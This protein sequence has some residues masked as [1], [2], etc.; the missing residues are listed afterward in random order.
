MANSKIYIDCSPYDGPQ[1][2]ILQ[3]LKGGLEEIGVALSIV[4]KA[5][6]QRSGQACSVGLQRAEQAPQG[7]VMARL[8]PTP[9]G[10]FAP[11]RAACV[12]RAACVYSE[13]SD[14]E[15]PQLCRPMGLTPVLLL[16]LLSMPPTEG[17]SLP[18]TSSWTCTVGMNKTSRRPKSFN[19]LQL[20]VKEN[21]PSYRPRSLPALSALPIGRTQ[22]GAGASGNAL[23]QTH[24][25]QPPRAQSRAD[26]EGWIW[27]A[28]GSNQDPD[29]S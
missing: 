18:K 16:P 1:T 20:S 17:L 28:T 14:S 24:M 7:E 5:A 27:R 10:D 22:P 6:T 4:W 8:T 2:N 11:K 13:M 15:V 9:G 23:T 3:P 25:D 12:E 29:S 19:V 21:A 26:R